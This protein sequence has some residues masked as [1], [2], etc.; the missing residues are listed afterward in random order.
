MWFDRFDICEAWYV[1]A[2]LYH[3]G[4]GSDT[5]A[6]FGRLHRMEFKISPAING[7]EDL[8]ENG[9]AIFN[10]LVNKHQGKAA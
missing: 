1:F 2:T 7:P 9:Q 8:T 4:M 5:Y 3:E 10:N 6:I